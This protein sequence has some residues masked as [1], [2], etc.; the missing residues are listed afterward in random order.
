MLDTH[1]HLNFPPLLEKVDEIVK[2]SK[3]AGVKGVI[4]ASSNLEDS[5]ISVELS[6]KYPDLLFASVGVHPQNVVSV[7]D[8]LVKLDQ[9]VQ[10][11]LTTVVAIGET[12][13][14]FSDAPHQSVQGSVQKELF[15]GQ[16][17]IAQKYNLPL[18]IHARQAN[19]EA[20]E[21]LSS[22]KGVRL[23]TDAHRGFSKATPYEA[24]SGVFHCYSGGKKRISKILALPGAWYFGF[25][26]NLTYEDGLREVIKLIPVE[27]IIIETDSPFLT[28]VPHRGEINTPIYLPLIQQKINEI[29]GR[30]LTAQI[31]QNS[32]NLFKI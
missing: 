28:P 8:K 12:G 2:N 11:S 24:C 5:K 18:I 3:K 21:I 32:K 14:D 9:L 17:K 7:S 31:L 23:A 16:I 15:L 10:S 20:M 19:D 26:G 27:R 13:L 1:A 30:D 6:S 4:V 22:F 29:F 25:D